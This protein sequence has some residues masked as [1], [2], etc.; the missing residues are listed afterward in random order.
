MSQDSVWYQNCPQRSKCASR[1]RVNTFSGNAPIRFIE[2]SSTAK[3]V[4]QLS[5]ALKEC[6]EYNTNQVKQSSISRF[7]TSQIHLK[8][9]TI[10][11][12]NINES[13]LNKH[14]TQE[15][16]HRVASNVSERSS[17]PVFK[18]LVQKIFD[19]DDE[20]DCKNVDESESME[21]PSENVKNYEELLQQKHVKSNITATV[22]SLKQKTIDAAH[23]KKRINSLGMSLDRAKI[24]LSKSRGRSSQRANNISL[25]ESY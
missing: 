5:G 11:D 9:N 15:S 14:S 19:F 22:R 18:K 21:T 7:R 17:K 25:R 3:K 10:R 6:M 24:M 20:P 13:P 16:R 8:F 1:T 2:R 12:M 4:E 23:S